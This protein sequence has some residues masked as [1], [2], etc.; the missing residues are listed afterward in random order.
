MDYLSFLLQHGSAAG[1]GT[2]IFTIAGAIL[3]SRPRTCLAPGAPLAELLAADEM[4]VYRGGRIVFNGGGRSCEAAVLGV[5]ALPDAFSESLSLEIMRAP[6]E[7]TVVHTLRPHERA[8]EIMTMQRQAK[9]AG[10]MSI[11]DGLGQREQIEMANAIVQGTHPSGLSSNVWTYNL[12]VVV[13]AESKAKLKAALLPVERALTLAGATATREGL[14]AEAAWWSVLPIFPEIHRRWRFLTFPIAALCVPQTTTAGIGRHDWADHEIARFRSTEGGIYRFTFHCTDKD[15]ELGHM[16]VVAPA[17]AGK[18]SFMCHLTS[19]VL[20]MS[21]T[22]CVLF[23]RDCGTEVFTAVAGGSYVRFEAMETDSAENTLEEG[24]LTARVNPFH[25]ENNE[26]NREFL[27]RWIPTLMSST[28][29]E[30]DR[31]SIARAGNIAYDYLPANMRSLRDVY[32]CAFPADS[33]VRRE[34]ARWTGN[35]PMGRIF[36]A[37]SDSSDVNARLVAYDCTHAFDRKELAS[38]LVSYLIHRIWS[39]SRASAT[40]TL[41]YIDETEPMLKHAEFERAFRRGLQEGRKLRQVFVSCFQR[42]R[43]IDDLKMGGLFRGQCP[44]VVLLPNH[45]ATAED[46]ANYELTDAELDFVLGRSHRSYA[47]AALIKRYKGGQS[48][49][50]DT[51]LNPLGDLARTYSSGRAPVLKLRKLIGEHGSREGLQSFLHP[52]S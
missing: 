11:G 9:V 17:G 5:Q 52:S 23:D 49:I 18:T 8:S 46:Y 45:Q 50:V 13:Y 29:T 20:S 10:D 30:D 21:N 34:L 14:A 36:N 27:T 39:R 28:P 4:V 7:L 33:T 26:A 32:R 1:T 47:H 41:V 24:D 44:T 15:E 12:T 6:C 43:A 3:G 51:S 19:H 42:P 37:D 40:P 31:E 16:F 35:D 2:A 25:L 38:A 48:A 22:R